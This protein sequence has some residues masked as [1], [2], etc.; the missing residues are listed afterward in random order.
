MMQHRQDAV[1]LSTW[2]FVDFTSLIEIHNR[3]AMCSA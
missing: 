2:D 1:L 3:V